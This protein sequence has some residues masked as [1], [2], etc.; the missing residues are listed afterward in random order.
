MREIW[1]K[2]L[3]AQALKSCPKSN[4][5]PNLITLVDILYH[6]NASGR[7]VSLLN[8]LFQFCEHCAIADVC[9]C[10]WCNNKLSNA[11]LENDPKT[12]CQ[13]LMW[14]FVT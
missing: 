12:G 6:K 9:V 7:D 4:K 10:V 13:M 1:A 11:M 2:L 3:F 8:S 5:L 14:L